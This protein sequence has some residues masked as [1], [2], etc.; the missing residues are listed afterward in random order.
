MLYDSSIY[1]V[2][3]DRYGVPGA[4]VPLSSPADANRQI[5]GNPSGDAP[6]RRSQRPGRWRRLFPLAPLVPDGMGP[7]RRYVEMF[8]PPLRCSISIRGS[9]ILGTRAYLRVMGVGFELCRYH[10]QPVPP[11]FLAGSLSIYSGDR[12]CLSPR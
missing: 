9:S 5:L 11:R 6:A 8:A 2:R 4:R 10:S 3:R 1:P 7:L 12:C